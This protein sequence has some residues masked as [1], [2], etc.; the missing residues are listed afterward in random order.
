[1]RA[2]K[3]ELNREGFVDAL[4]TWMRWRGHAIPHNMLSQRFSINDNKASLLALQKLGRNLGIHIAY[5]KREKKL[6]KP[7]NFPLIAIMHGGEVKAV[8]QMDMQGRLISSQVG[9]D[10]AID[11]PDDVIGWLQINISAKR[12]QA[13]C[14][15]IGMAVA[16][17]TRQRSLRC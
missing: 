11:L 8:R 7:D 15:L 14:S 16:L 1:M 5:K 6:P 2:A 17:L 9:G 13:S 3:I 4:A 10:A 12:L